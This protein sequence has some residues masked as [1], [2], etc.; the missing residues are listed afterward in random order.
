MYI[1]FIPLLV[2]FHEIAF[3]YFMVQNLKKLCVH[4][5]FVDVCLVVYKYGRVCHRI[6]MFKGP[7][8]VPVLILHLV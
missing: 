2:P 4:M 1:K 6:C 8:W 5:M 7:R 3:L